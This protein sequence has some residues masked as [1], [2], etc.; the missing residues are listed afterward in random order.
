MGPPRKE[1]PL[2][3]AKKS[4]AKPDCGDSI[5][6]F[7][8]RCQLCRSFLP[9]APIGRDRRSVSTG[10]AAMND[11]CN[12]APPK[13][14]FVHHFGGGVVCELTIA[15]RAPEPG[16]TFLQEIEWTGKPKPKH[17]AQYRQWILTTTQTLCDRWNR[18]ILYALSP[19]PRST[20][21]WSFLPGRAPRLEQKWP[22]ALP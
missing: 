1:A 21:L 7:T 19:N 17:I 13:L 6:D 10:G 3:P 11:Q 9:A 5:V 22:F 15:D 8:S 20:E 18:S 14:H 12:P 4:E 2:I 16:R